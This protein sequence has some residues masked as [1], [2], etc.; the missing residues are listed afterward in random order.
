MPAREFKGIGVRSH[1][2]SLESTLSRQGLRKALATIEPLTAE[3]EPFPA[4]MAFPMMPITKIA[5]A[6]GGA[7][8]RVRGCKC[9][10][11]GA[12]PQVLPATA[13]SLIVPVSCSRLEPPVGPS[14]P[15]SSTLTYTCPYVRRTFE[16]LMR[17]VIP[18]VRDD[19]ALAPTLHFVVRQLVQ[20]W[21]TASA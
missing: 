15:S 12:A 21:Q 9:R 18:I 17:G 5:H 8:T 16:T 11:Y 13:S 4:I 7:Y 1:I 19:P 2:S 10:N 20:P 3:F 14:T 6:M